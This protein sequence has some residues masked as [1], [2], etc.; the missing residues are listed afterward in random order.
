M[1]STPPAIRPRPLSEGANGSL[2]KNRRTQLNRTRNGR[3]PEQN[4]RLDAG[5]DS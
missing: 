5:T 1:E 4:I 3:N 2:K